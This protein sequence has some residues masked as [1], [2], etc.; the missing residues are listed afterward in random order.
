MPNNKLIILSGL[1]G[2]GKSTYCERITQERAAQGKRSVVI[3]S[4]EIRKKFLGKYDDLHNEKFVWNL[5]NALIYDHKM[6][7]DMAVILDAT[8][9]TNKKRYN[10]ANRFKKWYNE[11]ELVIMQ[12]PIETCLIQ[13]EQ[14]P[15]IKWVP[16]DVILSM[17]NTFDPVD[18]TTCWDYFTSVVLVKPEGEIKLERENYNDTIRTIKDLRA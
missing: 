14:R 16:K 5:F 4:D 8:F 10:Y 2:S 13:N 3:S 15:K 12:T 11:V 7:D 1:P 18:F 17:D 6:E 9:L